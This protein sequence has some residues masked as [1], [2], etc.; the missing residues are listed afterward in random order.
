MCFY[1]DA[2]NMRYGFV[3]M[4]SHNIKQTIACFYFLFLPPQLWYW[5]QSFC[6]LAAVTFSNDY[7]H[8]S[9][10]SLNKW[11]ETRQHHSEHLPYRLKQSSYSTWVR[12]SSFTLSCTRP[13]PIHQ[14]L[15]PT[16][17][18]FP[19]E[20][21]VPLNTRVS[22]T[23]IFLPVR[24]SGSLFYNI[25]ENSHLHHTFDTH[26]TISL[27]VSV[28]G[29][30]HLAHRQRLVL[31]SVLP[32]HIAY[33]FPPPYL[34]FRANPDVATKH[35]FVSYHGRLKLSRSKFVLS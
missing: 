11:L 29:V 6:L 27:A 7:C 20:P 25:H 34:F 19:G 31:P 2:T 26:C 1:A 30:F 28:S 35:T 15:L 23:L 4:H 14:R 22:C 13:R 12:F 21:T 32:C 5:T 10:T 3:T 18:L 16:I 9:Q 8:L 24:G 33:R 17:L